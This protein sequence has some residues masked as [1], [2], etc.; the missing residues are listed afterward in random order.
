MFYHQF[1]L[2]TREQKWIQIILIQDALYRIKENF[3]KEF[4]SVMQ[5]KQQEIAKIREKN[6]RLKQIYLDLNEEQ[7]LSEPQFGDAENPEL[8]FEVK[9]NEIKVEKYLTPEQRK[10]LEEQLAEE[11]RR[12][13]LEKLDNWR[14]RALMDMM[15]GVLQ[16]RREDELKKVKLKFF[17]V[18]FFI[19]I[20]L[21]DIPVP[22]FVNEKAKEEWNADEQKAYQVYEQRV[23]ELNEE[24]EKLKKV[25]FIFVN[26]LFFKF[27]ILNFKVFSKSS[28]AQ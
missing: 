13:E 16:I 23:K 9:D 15:S 27:G 5:R 18:L 20:L 6:Q 8:L 17:L 25:S 2:F 11:A 12:R 7:Q 21:K 14:E 4:A 19:R 24:R 1:E 26:I 28:L 10:Q 22:S 3:N